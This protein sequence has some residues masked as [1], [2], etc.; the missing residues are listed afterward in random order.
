[1]ATTALSLCGLEL[2]ALVITPAIAEHAPQRTTG[3]A[4]IPAFAHA[5][6]A[7]FARSQ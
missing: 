1:M 4:Q 2:R 5:R 3:Y 7:G 6:L